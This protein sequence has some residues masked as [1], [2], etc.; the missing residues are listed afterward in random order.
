VAT[1]SWRSSLRDSS[2]GPTLHQCPCPPRLLSLLLLRHVQ[3]LH[4]SRP[5]LVLSPRAERG[6]GLGAVAATVAAAGD[7][8]QLVE[9]TRRRHL[10]GVHPGPLSQPV[11]GKGKLSPQVTKSPRSGHGGTFL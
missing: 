11:R 5:F 4:P 6:L 9:A 3:P 1:L 8:M 10:H 7:V 2:L